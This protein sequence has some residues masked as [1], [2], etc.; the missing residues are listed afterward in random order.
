M[1]KIYLF[2]LIFIPTTI[3]LPNAF[4]EFY[5]FVQQNDQK[6]VQT[7]SNNNQYNIHVPNTNIYPVNPPDLSWDDVGV[8]FNNTSSQILITKID[9]RTRRILSNCAVYDFSDSSSNFENIKNYWMDRQL[10]D[11]NDFKEFFEDIDPYLKSRVPCNAKALY[12]L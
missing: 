10:L 3:F 12:T 4:G 5:Y 7:F 1:N 8:Y 6:L 2:F 9:K 11:E